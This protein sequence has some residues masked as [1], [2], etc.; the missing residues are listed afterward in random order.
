LQRLSQPHHQRLDQ[1]PIERTH[2]VVDAQ[3]RLLAMDEQHVR[4]T[5]FLTALAPGLKEWSAAVLCEDHEPRAAPMLDQ[6][7]GGFCD[8][9]LAGAHL[10]Y[11]E[12]YLPVRR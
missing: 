9:P 10:A 1:L 11:D 8:P 5:L 7:H 4:P 12:R 6:S 3:C 2:R